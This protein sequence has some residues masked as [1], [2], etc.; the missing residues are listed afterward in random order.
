MKV[1]RTQMIKEMDASWNLY[2]I[3]NWVLYVGRVRGKRDFRLVHRENFEA[4]VFSGI[5]DDMEKRA[6]WTLDPES[7]TAKKKKR[8]RG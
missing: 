5:T 1:W 4:Y 7:P 2:L 3:R 8:R 6:D